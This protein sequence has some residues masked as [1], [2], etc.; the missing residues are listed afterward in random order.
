MKRTALLAALVLILSPALYAQMDKPL[1]LTCSNQKVVKA[2]VRN[3]V[4]GD[5]TFVITTP[6]NQ[7]GEHIPGLRPSDFKIT[8]GKKV[9]K[10]L[11]VDELTAVENTVMRIVFM[12]DNSQSMSPHLSILRET[13]AK[14]MKRFTGAVRLSIIL[15]NEGGSSP[16]FFLGDKPLSLVRLPYTNDKDRAVDYTQKMLTER[17]LTRKTYLYEGIYAVREQLQADTGKVDRSYAIIFSDGKDLGSVV[18]EGTALSASAKNTTYFTID[19]LTE[20]NDFLVRLAE[21]SGGEH[22]QAKAADDLG[23]IFDAIA[24]KIVAKGYKVASRFNKPPSV[25]IDPS[26]KHLTMEEEIIRETFP[27]LNYVFF[28]QGS[29]SI[30]VRYAQRSSGDVAK[31]D[32]SAIEGGALDFY[33]NVLNVIG[34][35]MRSMPGSAITV[36]GYVNDFAAEKNNATLAKDRALAVKTYLQNVWGIEE[37]RVTTASGKLP[38]QAS[39]TKDTMGRA[40]NGRVEI[41][42]DN[43]DLM[44]PV[45]FVRRIA[46]MNPLAVQFAANV[47]AEEGVASWVLTVEQNGRTFD[48]RKGNRLEPRI[49]WNWYNMQRQAPAIS[50]ELRC[51]LLVTDSVGDSKTSAPAVITVSKVEKERRQNV[52]TSDDGITREKISLILFP[53]NV[54]EPGERNQVIMDKFVYPRITEGARVEVSGFTDVIGKEDYNL[55]LSQKRA[56]AVYDILKN[57]YVNLDDQHLTYEGYGETSPVF[58][59][60]LPEGRFYN[61][62]VSLN[63]IRNPA[64]AA[65]EDVIER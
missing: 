41:S 30:P 64:G 38:P 29:A 43:W 27:M 63:I 18:D 55:G 9:A 1:T 50:G 23:A 62:T 24:N 22:F 53:F 4:E 35:R 61:R 13:L 65:Q 36:T 45:T 15:F 7:V 44:K 3:I 6:V 47:R 19:Y 5:T 59:N 25:A 58:S 48:M 12:V 20:R 57:R 32:E 26:V 46:T 28:D 51:S 2:E 17:N 33:Y 52:S 60:D 37:G 34:S 42:S 49:N 40:E 39:A 14:V 21:Q 8:K 31:F 16:M 11:R 10:V 56:K 54:A